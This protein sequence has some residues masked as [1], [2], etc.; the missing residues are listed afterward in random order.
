MYF[1]TEKISSFFRGW[2]MTKISV[3]VPCYNVKKWVGRCLDSLIGQTLSD[4]EIICIDDKSTDNTLTILKQYAE[5]DERISIIEMPENRGVAVARNMGLAVST[6][7]Y[8]GFIDPDDYVDADFYEKLY[9]AIIKSGADVAKA[10]VETTNLKDNI[11][12]IGDLNKQIKQNHIVW[13]YQFWSGLYNHAFL[14]EN[15]IRFP[16]E[17]ITGQD[18][19]FLT[20]VTL[21]T[22]NIVLIDDTYYHYFLLNEG[23]LDSQVLNRRKSQSKLDMIKHKL[24]LIH[25]A[26]L[27]DE[28]KTEFI[29]YQVIPN[30]CYEIKKKFKHKPHK[31]QLFNMLYQYNKCPEYQD[32][33]K[34]ALGKR[35]YEELKRN[36]LLKHKSE[37][38]FCKERMPDGRRNIYVFGK[39]VWSY[40]KGK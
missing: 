31:R 33:I 37:K 40:R 9:A 30:I 14:T 1:G 12:Y 3:I 8:I 2:V 36:K 18:A 23:S 39:R 19:V 35:L 20:H 7:P 16:D 11:S 22:D 5:A 26:N 27:T 6:A 32:T 38:L 17:V 28:Q 21:C 13:A 25:D 15:N 34:Q 24:R 29:K 4:I 10:A